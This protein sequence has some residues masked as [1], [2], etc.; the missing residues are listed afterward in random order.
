MASDAVAVLDAAGVGRAHI[1]GVS[2]GGMIAQELALQCPQRV[3]SL[4]LACTASGGPHAV[5]AEP[6][7]IQTLTRR[8]MSPE[9]AIEAIIP[10]IY[11]P[12]TPRQLIDEDMAIRRKWY[13]TAEGYF[14]QLQAIFGWQAFDRLPKISAPTLVIHGESDRLV[15][16][17]NA[18]LIAARIP[19]AKLVLLPD[20]G[21]IFDTDQPIASHSAIMEFLFVRSDFEQDAKAS[22][23]ATPHPNISR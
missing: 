4:I 7:A 14:A 17:G 11:H 1:L 2:M 12:S 13:P 8:D 20:A 18:K 3:R 6:A 16:P 21:H 23:A 10:F 5:Q 22:G 15:P 19:N 9:E